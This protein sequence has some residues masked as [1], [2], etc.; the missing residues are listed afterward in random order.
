MDVDDGGASS[1]QCLEP[2][3][4]LATEPVP[5]TILVHSDCPSEA[6]PSVHD[7]LFNG[8]EKALHLDAMIVKQEAGWFQL[9]EEKRQKKTAEKLALQQEKERIA[10]EREDSRRTIAYLQQLLHKKLG[11]NIDSL[12]AGNPEVPLGTLPFL[13]LLHRFKGFQL[14]RSFLLEGPQ[15]HNFLPSLLG[16]PYFLRRY[17]RILV[18]LESKI[19]PWCL[20]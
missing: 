11:S 20:L 5:S 15:D 16:S 7:P 1:S 19:T 12:L 4:G 9:R 2:K 6:T 17:Q 8:A 13:P 10:K 14:L 3:L 18:I